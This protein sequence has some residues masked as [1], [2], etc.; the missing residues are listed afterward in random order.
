M[1]PFHLSCLLR[2]VLLQDRRK[3]GRTEE[4]DDQ[5]RKERS[6]LRPWPSSPRKQGRR[7]LGYR[8]CNI[9]VATTFKHVPSF[10]PISYNITHFLLKAARNGFL[11]IGDISR[12]GGKRSFSECKWEGEMKSAET[13]QKQQ[14]KIGRMMATTVAMTDRR[15]CN[16]SSQCYWA[17]HL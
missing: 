6:C 1:M 15:Y 16:R 3:D 14:E 9:V 10:S 11:R 2:S 5:R 7:Y 12:E 13:P 8:E 17:H 4:W